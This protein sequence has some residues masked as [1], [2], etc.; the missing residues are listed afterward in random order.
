[1]PAELSGTREWSLQLSQHA[2][3]AGFASF[4]NKNQGV[5]KQDPRGNRGHCAFRRRDRWVG[6]SRGGVG[7][8]GH[9]SSARWPI[10]CSLQTSN[11]YY[12]TAVGGGGRNT[13]VIHSDAT[14]IGSWEQF[15]L[16]CTH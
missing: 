15:R 7:E 12:L 14:R 16:N 6:P 5:Q 4:P 1:M 11:G 9:D 8:Y 13:D 10:T 3:N 2:E